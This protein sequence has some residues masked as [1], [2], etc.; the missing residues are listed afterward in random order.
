MIGQG[1]DTA[2][3]SSLGSGPRPQRGYVPGV[4]DLF[5]IGHLNVIGNARR[6]CEWLVVGVVSDEVTASVKGRLPVIPLGE[7][8]EILRALRDVD[9]VVVDNHADKFDSW[10]EFRY[11]VIF[12]GD[13]WRGTPR[14]LRLEANLATVGAQIHYFPYTMH[15]SST[16][17]R[18]ALGEFAS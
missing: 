1:E 7:R 5:H 14:A 16:L 11:D 18:A 6:E 15:T 9:E 12:K 10:Q 17:L 2:V 3:G 13:D 8:I 4:F